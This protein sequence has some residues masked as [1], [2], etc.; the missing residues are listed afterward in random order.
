MKI[1]IVEE[2]TWEHHNNIAVFSSKEKARAFCNTVYFLDEDTGYWKSD[3]RS[4]PSYYYEIQEYD[5]DVNPS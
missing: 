5:V 1:Y 2:T 4:S 3:N